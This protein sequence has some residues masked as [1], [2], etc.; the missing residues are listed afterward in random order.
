[1]VNA[2]TVT[3][4]WVP[5]VSGDPVTSYVI[6]AVVTGSGG[7]QFTFDTG[8]T[9]ASFIVTDVPPGTYLV[10]VRARNGAG[11]GNIAYR[12]ITVGGDLARCPPNPPGGL[13][14]G[15]TGSLLG[16]TWYESSGACAPITYVI[17]AG[18][19]PG[20]SNLANFATNSTEAT[21]RANDVPAG[22]YFVRV[23]ARN[24]AG[25]S[26]PSPEI[27]LIIVGSSSATVDVTGRWVGLA[28][29]GFIVS[30]GNHPFFGRT[31]CDLEDDLLLDM[32]QVGN[33]VSW[34]STIRSRRVAGCSEVGRVGGFGGGSGTVS[35][36]GLAFRSQSSCGTITL[37]CVMTF[38]GT[39]VG[40]RMSG[41]VTLDG[42][43]AA[44]PTL[45]GTFA[46]TRQ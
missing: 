38:A 20:A 46:V 21:F 13:Y 12:T 8:S 16:L 35:G 11:L 27:V 6:E 25:T 24:N 42:S 17:E 30:P 2:A 4:S 26:L 3:L 7:P 15:V 41:I 31:S 43:P 9:N 14:G 45:L 37:R 5:P 18:S 32:T 28:P 22:A 10:G 33:T 34:T 19:A 39:V 44:P 29:D 36:A 40:N 1:M 23:R